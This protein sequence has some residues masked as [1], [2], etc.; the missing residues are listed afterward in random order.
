MKK[1][2]SKT[3]SRLKYRL[4]SKSKSR[5]IFNIKYDTKK[6]KTRKNKKLV[7]VDSKKFIS[8]TY[9]YRYYNGYEDK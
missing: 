4:K 9:L 7:V 8:P 3:K 2:K 6:N 5:S 1:S